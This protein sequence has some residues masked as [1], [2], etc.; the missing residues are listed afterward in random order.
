MTG[1]KGEVT[2]IPTARF[3]LPF[4]LALA[5]SRG[6]AGP[7][8]FVNETLADES[9]HAFARKVTVREDAALSALYPK[10]RG[11]RLT[12]HFA[13]GREDVVT[14]MFPRGEP[15]NPATDDEYYDKF[16]ANA[17]G[18]LNRGEADQVIAAVEQIESMAIS[19]LVALAAGCPRPAESAS[20]RLA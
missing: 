10:E 3:S 6:A 20:A 13:D 16:R 7:V 18:V 5:A 2:D 9:L 11:A 14:V 15:E 4:C 12:V 19:E 1:H 17:V 8:E